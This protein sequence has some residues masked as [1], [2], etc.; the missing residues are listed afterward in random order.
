MTAEAILAAV[1]LWTLLAMV[2]GFAIGRRLRTSAGAPQRH[3]RQP[4]RL[5]F[6]K[7]A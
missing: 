1:T 5:P 2:L 7:T 6:W 3:R 4:R